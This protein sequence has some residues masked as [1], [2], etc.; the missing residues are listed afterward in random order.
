MDRTRATTLRPS[1][2]EG[3]LRAAFRELH[4]ASL[5]GFALLVTLGDR[6]LAE[7]LAAE[8]LTDGARNAHALQH[9]ERAAAW[10]RS[11]VAR[12]VPRRTGTPA[13]DAERRSTLAQ[14][15]VDDGAY[16]A[17]RRL[18][19]RARVALVAAWVEQ[20]D[21]RDVEAILHLRPWRRARLVRRARREFLDAYLRATPGPLPL[22][23]DP[24]ATGSLASRVRAV[25]VRTL[26]PGRG[27]A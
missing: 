25:T 1:A 10:L 11:R 17:I 22:A 23:T 7:R 20:L 19:P 15:G 6:R 8:A 14:L 16:Q 27:D 21:A 9:P 5:H 3:M 12:G 24:G 4:G 2:E 13:D 18:E 26:S